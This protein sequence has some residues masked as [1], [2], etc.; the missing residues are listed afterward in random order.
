MKFSSKRTIS[1]LVA[2]SMLVTSVFSNVMVAN[3]D[4]DLVADAVASGSAVSATNISASTTV[5]SNDIFT[6][7]SGANITFPTSGAFRYVLADGIVA[8][9]SQRSAFEWRNSTYNLTSEDGTL[10]AVTETDN[11][12]QFSNGNE[13]LNIG[14]EVGSTVNAALQ[15]GLEKWLMFTVDQATDITVL[16][17]GGNG[18]IQDVPV[19]LCRYDAGNITVV[20][21]GVYH[22]E[23]MDTYV[24]DKNETKY[25][26]EHNNISVPTLHAPEAGTYCF[27]QPAKVSSLNIYAI[28]ATVGGSTPAPVEPTSEATT[29]ETTVTITETTTVTEATTEETTVATTEET[30]IE[31]TTEETSEA[32][33]ELVLGDN[34][35]AVQADA[36]VSGSKVAV[37]Y[38]LVGN[39]PTKGFNNF[40]MNLVYDNTVL[41]N[42]VIDAASDI[43]VDGIDATG[44]AVKVPV[45]AKLDA[46][47]GKVV[48]CINETGVNTDKALVEYVTDGTLFTITYDVI[49]AEATETTVGV[50]VD[51][52]NTVSKD[53]SI[54]GKL[55]VVEIPAVVDLT[56]AE[57]STD[58]STEATTD[59]VSTEATTDEVPTEATTDEA[60]T[61]AT[62]DAVVPTEPTTEATTDAAVPTEPTT[63]A[64]TDAPVVPT[65]P[66]TE[67][68]TSAPAVRP[69]S[70]GGGGGGGS[71]K[72]ATTTTTEATTEAVTTDNTDD[73]TDTK[74]APVITKD[75]QVT[76]GSESVLIGDTTYEAYGAPYIQPESNSTL[77]PLR[78][79]SLAI[80]GGN[81]DN[82]DADS[83]VTWDG[84]TKTATIVAGSVVVKFTA[85]SDIMNVGGKDEVMDNGVKAEIKDARMYVPFRA[86]GKAL[87]VEVTWDAATKTA[88]Y[89]APAAAI[90]VNDTDA[91]TTEATT[92]AVEEA[93]EETTSEAGTSEETTVEAETDVE[94]TTVAE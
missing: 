19:I 14:T 12:F 37:A 42:P 77:V 67:A 65:E 49:N 58:E 81:V 4:V 93:S 57:E 29:E 28:Q 2:A 26:A 56:A 51:T 43:T 8:M 90:A 50:S 68:T 44:N 53:D 5:Y 72:P 38:K 59:E 87:G 70:G 94:T 22:R 27:I 47:T 45:E 23:S 21:S 1:R 78:I 55:D 85:G 15:N 33:T 6:Q 25:V 35:V 16:A 86:L 73:N 61:E 89:K 75:V 17:G 71:Y 69:S 92:E 36:T 39:A 20:D 13:K 7:L 82:P 32:T 91:V 24:N 64:T 3:A 60:P 83:A 40:T 84:T 80:L 41:A 34:E 79:V 62:T 31:T 88:A 30:T 48:F 11:V 54:V 66:T 9:N 74:P 46:S 63:E 52:L 10:T 76:I 18:D